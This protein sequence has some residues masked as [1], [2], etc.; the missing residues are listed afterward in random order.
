MGLAALATYAQ[1]IMMV[2][3]LAQALGK[4]GEK[5]IDYVKDKNAESGEDDQSF[6]ES[7]KEEFGDQYEDVKGKVEE[8]LTKAEKLDVL[9]LF[10]DKE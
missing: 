2:V 9:G 3:Q 5:V 6:L 10:T 4:I 8:L 1:E 7:L